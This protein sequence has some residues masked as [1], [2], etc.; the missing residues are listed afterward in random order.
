MRA[1]S[2]LQLCSFDRSRSVP[3][4]IATIHSCHASNLPQLH[5]PLLL[6]LTGGKSKRVHIRTVGESLPSSMHC[7]LPPCPLEDTRLS[8]ECLDP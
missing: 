2:L 1:D 3:R 6:R 4:T 8:H 7:K 5:L